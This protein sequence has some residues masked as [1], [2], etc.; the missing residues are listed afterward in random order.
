MMISRTFKLCNFEPGGGQ[1]D[2]RQVRNNKLAKTMKVTECELR[3][4][5]DGLEQDWKALVA[6][7]FR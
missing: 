4:D 5:A 1:W 2:H 6:E 3:N 7:E